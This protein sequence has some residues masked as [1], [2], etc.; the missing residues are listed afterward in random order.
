MEGDRR[1]PD[2]MSRTQPARMTSDELKAVAGL[3]TYVLPYWRRFA[4]AQACLLVSTIVGLMFPYFAGRLVDAAHRPSN[5]ALRVIPDSAFGADINAVALVL[6]SLLAVQGICAYFQT[7]CMAEVGER[8]LADL[9][10]AVY[11]RLIRL[12]MTFL[13]ERRVGELASRVTTD[14][15]LIQGV[16]TGSVPLFWGQVILL[17]GGL[18]LVT[19]TSVRLTVVMLVSLPLVMG[20]AVVFGKMTRRISAETQDRLADTNVIVQETLQ[21]V[22]NVKAFGNEE[23]ETARYRK[24]LLSAISVVVRGARYQGAFG[25]TVS[26]MAFGAMVVVM[27]YGARLVESRDLSVGELTRFLLYS[28]YIGMATGQFTRLYGE[29]QRALGATHRVREILQQEPENV[30]GQPDQSLLSGSAR[31]R[32]TER[33]AGHVTFESVTFSYPS[34][35]DVP[36]LRELSF[37]ICGGQRIA[38][39]GPSGAGKSTIIALVLR[40]YDPD[41]GRITIDGHNLRDFPRHQLRSQMAIVPQD[42]LLFGGTIADNIAYGRPGARSTDI[43]DAARK[44]YAHDFIIG[45]PEGYQTIVGDRGLKLSG[46]QRQRV[47]IARAILKNPAIL[48]LD[49]ATS[50][51]D[52]ESESLVKQALDLLMQSRTSITIAHRLAT[53]RKADCILVA[54][55]GQIVESGTH[56]QLLKKEN[57]IYRN[58]SNLQLDLR[59]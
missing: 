15:S 53:V 6:V 32:L 41:R 44:A 26:F 21:D 36:V 28:M 9:R 42:V 23:F 39:V 33:V 38:L 20:I 10:L 17:T 30:D 52:S 19:M 5:H 4:A 56:E 24:A 37:S 7:Y 16:M 27:W 40:F 12:S 50:S 35:K 57:G 48:I 45:F 11:A 43:E 13:T 22:A 55:E 1:S 31:A 14:L 2:T 47:A 46:G 51:L 8:S 59:E 58:L 18:V 3:L 34:R 49:E 29:L 25:G 54:K